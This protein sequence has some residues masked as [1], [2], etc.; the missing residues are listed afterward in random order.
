VGEIPA[1]IRE[2]LH[3]EGWVVVESLETFDVH[4]GQRFANRAMALQKA[5]AGDAL[6]ASRGKAT[7][8][9]EL[10]GE[11]LTGRIRRSAEPITAEGETL[12]VYSLDS[13]ERHQRPARTAPAERPTSPGATRPWTCPGCD[14]TWQL[15]AE[16]PEIPQD[17]ARCPECGEPPTQFAPG[18]VVRVREVHGARTRLGVVDEPV[19]ADCYSFEEDDVVP[20]EGP[21]T[22]EFMV[23]HLDEGFGSRA[24]VDPDVEVEIFASLPVD[25][26][27]RRILASHLM[28]GT[29]AALD[30][31]EA[32]PPDEER[33]LF[34][35]P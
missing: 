5:F 31:I 15:V 2:Q 9:G 32:L 30:Q 17:R 12:L 14:R 34:G 10:E 8:S 4:L 19:Q 22:G 6:L 27:R 1:W 11:F 26:E 3:V 21:Y 23:W 25:P 33:R 20:D 29:S 18:Q 28:R 24:P 7:T 16:E 13:V 35:G